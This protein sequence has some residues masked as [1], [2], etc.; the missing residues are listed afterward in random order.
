MYDVDALVARYFELLDGEEWGLE[1][2]VEARLI[3]QQLG[4][5][6]ADLR[7]IAAE[8]RL[9]AIYLENTTQKA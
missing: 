5:S 8:C 1:Q 3:T 6:E 9:R 7:D 4:F 2:Q